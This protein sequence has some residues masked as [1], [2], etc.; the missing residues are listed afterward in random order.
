MELLRWP[1]RSVLSNLVVH[2]MGQVTKTLIA[3]MP[4]STAVDAESTSKLLI[5]NVSLIKRPV[6]EWANKTSKTDIS[7][8]F[9]IN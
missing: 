1:R 2:P 9:D 8:G 7:I 6:V 3:M 5:L 4:K